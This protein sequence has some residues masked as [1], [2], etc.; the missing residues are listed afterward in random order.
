[1]LVLTRKL[2]QKIFIG[3]NIAVVVVEIDRGKVRLGIE[4]PREIA[5]ARDDVARD[6]VQT[7]W[8][9]VDLGGEG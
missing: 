6:G 4:A 7:M 8:G 5:I 9:T 3:D 1:M 2:G